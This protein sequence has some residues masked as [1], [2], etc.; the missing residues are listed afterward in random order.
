MQNCPQPLCKRLRTQRGE[1]V[2]EGF[3]TLYGKLNTANETRYFPPQLTSSADVT[4]RM[5]GT[6]NMLIL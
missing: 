1:K 5:S 2:L 3:K 6:E 4:N